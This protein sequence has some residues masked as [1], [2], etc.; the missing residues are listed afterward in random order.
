MVTA[1]MALTCRAVSHTNERPAPT[2]YRQ[3]VRPQMLGVMRNATENKEKLRAALPNNLIEGSMCT[4]TLPYRALINRRQSARFGNTGVVV[5]NL[6][7]QMSRFR[8]DEYY[9]KR[10]GTFNSDGKRVGAWN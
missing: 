6:A 9:G 2:S 5:N 7:E 8:N 4:Q 10:I 3:I 1:S